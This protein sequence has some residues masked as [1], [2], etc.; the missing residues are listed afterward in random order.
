MIPGPLDPV[1]GVG[2]KSPVPVSTSLYNPDKY[3]PDAVKTRPLPSDGFCHSPILSSMGSQVSSKLATRPRT[4]FG[5]SQ[6][7][8]PTRKPI[9]GMLYYC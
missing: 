3:G 5:S 2:D 7:L 6:K 8:P 1:T 9:T 4:V